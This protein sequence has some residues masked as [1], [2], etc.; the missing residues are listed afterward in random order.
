MDTALKGTALHLS[1]NKK[2]GTRMKVRVLELFWV[3][4][5]LVCPLLKIKK[6][7]SSSKKL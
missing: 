1:T 7:Y 4:A 2:I 5:L 6:I 3:L